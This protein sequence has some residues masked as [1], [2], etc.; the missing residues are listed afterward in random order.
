MHGRVATMVVQRTKQIAEQ[1]RALMERHKLTPQD[2]ERITTKPSRPGISS[3]TVR[4]LLAAEARTEPRT[5]TLR[6]IAEA[7]GETYQSAFPESGSLFEQ[8][9]TELGEPV[10]RAL[11]ALAGLNETDRAMAAGVLLGWIERHATAPSPETI[12]YP[13]APRSRIRKDVADRIKAAGELDE[14]S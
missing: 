1:L 10:A 14:E 2:I 13:G 11:E 7:I 8:A 4:R 9:R 12:S 5:D 6:R 3:V